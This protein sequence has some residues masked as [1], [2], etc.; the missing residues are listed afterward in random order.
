MR[1]RS[2]AVAGAMTGALLLAGCTADAG[3]AT[4]SSGDS[5]E[6]SVATEGTSTTTAAAPT[7]L[8]TE[9]SYDELGVK[10]VDAFD[11]TAAVDV[12]LSDSGST[13]GDGV[14]VDGATV[15]ITEGGTYRLSGTLS[16]GQVVV[17]TDDKDVN[18]ILDGVDITSEDIAA[19]DIE[20]ADEVVVWLA[21]GTTNTLASAAD[22]EAT[23]E[24]ESDVPNATLYSTAN[25]WIAGTGELTV[26]GS[27]EDGITS[28][29]GLVI[30]GGTIT[31][32][33]DD[34]G[35]RG[36][37]HLVIEDGTITVDVGG[38]ALRSDNED[39]A[40][41]DGEAVGVVW[42]SGG[43]V[44]ATAGTDAID[45]YRQVTIEGGEIELAAEDDG[46][47]AEGVLH[48]SGGTVDVTRSYE[49]LEGAVIRLSG[50]EGSIVASDDGINVSDG[51][52]SGGGMGDMG[53]GRG[54]MGGERPERNAGGAS[55]EATDDATGTSASTAAYSTADSGSTGA[56]DAVTTAMG[57]EQASSDLWLEITGG[58]WE[59]DADGDGLDSN[60]Y[61][62]MSGGTVVVSGP[63]NSGNGAIDVNGSFEITGGV[64]AASGSSGM[65]E[66]AEGD[67]QGVLTIAFGSSIPAGTVITVTDADGTHVASFTTQKVSQSLVLST[68]DLESG[69]EY[70]VWADASV[71]GDA[72]GPLVVD[73]SFSGGDELGSLTAD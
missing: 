43:T 40:N 65:L 36:K 38:D 51:S 53:G 24:D 14:T 30:E 22:A 58:T 63:E 49:G 67:G 64:L 73:G 25:M 27:P 70:T 60:G 16:A 28:K 39:V 55:S 7:A 57:G 1:Y 46:V 20:G 13:G 48:I 56:T 17:A 3:D 61:A 11:E 62:T 6:T 21:E 47:T 41:D 69:A 33:A 35:L 44:S 10:E 15:T 8:L 12:T 18:L 26:E 31:V 71:S 5:S 59:I 29:D 42:I 19:I 52:G 23:A 4:T 2:L 50:G 72:V 32:T 37:D 9:V 45:A 66:T 68:P 34:D 54:G